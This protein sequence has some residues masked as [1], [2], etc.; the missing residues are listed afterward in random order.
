MKLNLLIIALFFLACTNNK[1]TSPESPAQQLYSPTPKPPDIERIDLGTPPSTAE[2]IV[3]RTI[4]ISGVEVGI[5]TDSTVTYVRFEG[6]TAVLDGK[7]CSAPKGQCWRFGGV[8]VYACPTTDGWLLDIGP[9]QDDYA[10]E[11]LNLQRRRFSRMMSAAND[12][13]LQKLGVKNPWK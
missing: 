2:D 4:T 3:S 8:R 6:V 5:T 10:V 1:G 7:N 11:W 12:P 9:V 13:T